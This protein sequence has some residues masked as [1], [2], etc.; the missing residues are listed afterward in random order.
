MRKHRLIFLC[1]ALL[2]VW[3]IISQTEPVVTAEGPA[4][5]PTGK[6][7]ALTFDDGPRAD[8]TARL[9]DGLKERG[10]SA[11]FFL[12][13]EQIEENRE[14]VERMQAEG[15]QVGNHTWTHTR[16]QM[17][18]QTQ[19]Q[20][21]IARTNALLQEILGPGTYWIRPPYGLIKDTQ[22]SWFSAPLIKWSLDPEDWK[23]EN[24]Q[25]DVKAVLSEVKPGDIILMHDRIS[26]SVDAA[27]EIIDQLQAQGYTFV[28]VEELLSIYGTDPYSGL[29]CSGKGPL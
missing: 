12:I 14:L 19:A 26:A 23:L 15:H 24:A 9:L 25:A 5:I 11:T 7:V 16:L 2:F 10:A 27:L 8:T 17:L 29:I 22:F 3:S 21:E 4:E 20:E 28:T 1:V 13:G 18:N 6:Y